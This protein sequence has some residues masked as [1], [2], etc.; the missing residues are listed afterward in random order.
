MST[1]GDGLLHGSKMRWRLQ[2]DDG[3]AQHRRD[4]ERHE[5]ADEAVDLAAEQQREDDEQRVEAQRAPE[6][7]R[8]HDVALELLQGDE[9]QRD[10]ERHQRVLDERDDHRRRGAEDRA[11][12]RARAP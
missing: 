9:Q 4:R 8:R 7:V 1:S 11:D 10:P 5:R 2:V 12:V 3:L 6:D